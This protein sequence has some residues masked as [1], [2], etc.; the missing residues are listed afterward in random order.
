MLLCKTIGRYG[1]SLEEE[2][3]DTGVVKK[4]MKQKKEDRTERP[5]SGN[6]TKTR[7]EQRGKEM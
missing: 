6:C 3:V 2:R 1:S 7:K 5:E 4:K